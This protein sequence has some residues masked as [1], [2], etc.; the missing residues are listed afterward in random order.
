ME[1]QVANRVGQETGRP[2]LLRPTLYDRDT[3][4]AINAR[5]A[6]YDGRKLGEAKFVC[7]SLCELFMHHNR[8]PKH[9]GTSGAAP[10]KWAIGQQNT[11]L[12]ERL[13][14]IE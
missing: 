12:K 4:E 6:G 1:T 5:N 14:K 9:I 11:L 13:E 3:S 10:W 8:S 2:P 7:L